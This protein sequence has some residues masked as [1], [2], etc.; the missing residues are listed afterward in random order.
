MDYKFAHFWH[1]DVSIRKSLASLAGLL[2]QSGA[3]DGGHKMGEMRGAFVELEPADNTVIGEIFCDA[4]LGYAEM[5]GKLRLEG[6]RTTPAGATAQKIPD[7]NA[8][9]LTGFDVVVASE[10]GIGED[11]NAG[12]YRS[13]V[14]FAKFYGRTGEQPAKLHFEKRQSRGKA[15]ITGTAAHGRPSWIAYR[16]DRECGDGASMRGP[17]RFGIGWFVIDPWGKTFRWGCGFHRSGCGACGRTLRSFAL[18]A[19]AATSTTA[20]TAFFLWRISGFCGGCCGSVFGFSHGFSS[21]KRRLGLGGNLIGRRSRIE[22]GHGR[23]GQHSIARGMS[24]IDGGHF[25]AESYSGFLRF[26]FPIRPAKT[27]RGSQIPFGGIGILAG[28]FEITGQFKR[29]H[30]IAGLFVQIG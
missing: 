26:G 28:G 10:V 16:F 2:V 4:G 15:G 13:V 1:G 19:I 5:L 21:S 7:G 3:Y 18:A 27:F 12:T 25:R 29:N 11:E 17:R 22:T 6:I 20:T 23:R 24:G 30:G 14:R 9:G 8:E